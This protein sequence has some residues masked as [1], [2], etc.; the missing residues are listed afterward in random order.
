MRSNIYFTNEEVEILAKLLVL[1][2]REVIVADG[3][4]SDDEF[5]PFSY[6]ISNAHNF[7]IPIVGEVLNYI[8]KEGVDY[9]PGVFKEIAENIDN[10]NYFYEITNYARR[11]LI[12][13]TEKT[14]QS[15]TLRLNVETVHSDGHQD[16]EETAVMDIIRSVTDL[17]MKDVVSMNKLGEKSPEG[18]DIGLPYL[19][20]LETCNPLSLR[21]LEKTTDSNIIDGGNVICGE[22]DKK[23]D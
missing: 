17:T 23:M 9:V 18:F 11:V 7:P 13:Y 22:L 15:L 19:N 16:E 2:V 12:I 4:I 21:M 5:A 1:S 10:D 6:S 20:S 3:E 8:K 14:K